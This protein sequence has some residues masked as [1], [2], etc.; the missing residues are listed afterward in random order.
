MPSALVKFSVGLLLAAAMCMTAASAY[1][2]PGRMDTSKR[3][4]VSTEKKADLP[5]TVEMKRQEVLQD[6]RFSTGD[7][8]E[9]KDAIVGER[10][11]AIETKETREKKMAPRRE[12]VEPDQIPHKE[13]VW[14]R[15]Q[16]SRFSTS[17]DAYR[18]RVATRFQDKI[19]DASPFPQPTRAVTDQRTT[20]SKVNRFAFRK[21]GDQTITTTTAGGEATSSN[22]SDRSSLAPGSPT[23]PARR[24]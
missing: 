13:S 14:N 18:S 6:S 5:G 16:Q 17:E 4:R 1:S 20:F 12:L 3:A 9:K 15:K 7:L 11:S 22:V 19:G 8:R 21:N 2:A 23:A 10:R 24:R